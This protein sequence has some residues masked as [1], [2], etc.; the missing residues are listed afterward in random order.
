MV[1]KFSWKW[2][3]D[4]WHVLFDAGAKNSL[5]WEL[6]CKDA[7]KECAEEYFA[8]EIEAYSEQEAVYLSMVKWMM[9][10][11]PYIER[12]GYKIIKP[13]ELC[14]TGYDYFDG[15]SNNNNEKEQLIDIL[16]KELYNKAVQ[17]SME[18]PKK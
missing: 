5:E 17:I 14:F 4:E 9:H 8:K 16:G 3:D 6:D 12:K 7:L 15:F 2:H 10:A 11:V 1:F 18:K 13:H